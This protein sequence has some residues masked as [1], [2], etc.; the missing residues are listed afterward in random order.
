MGRKLAILEPIAV[1]GLILA[2]IWGLRY[3]HPRAWA[4]I[5]ALLVASHW[6]RGEGAAALGFRREN[7]AVC[8]RRFAPALGFLALTL[9]ASGLL[10]DTVRPMA[11]D[12]AAVTWAIYVPWGL[13]QQYL[14]NGYCLTRLQIAL[15]GRAAALAAAALFSVVH[16]PNW[17]LML[18]TLVAGYAA[19]RLYSSYR[20]LCFLG[21]AHGTVGVLLFL[22]VPDSISHHLVVGPGWYG[23]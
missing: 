3:H 23:R 21:L 20:N 9:L 4:P 22:V 12:R 13:F 8:L 17:F 18:V 14:L 7:L 10:L 6:W 2:Y 16:S 11:L 5:V 19:A 15:P 1:C